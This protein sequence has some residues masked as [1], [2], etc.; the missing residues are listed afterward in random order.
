[1]AYTFYC[2]GHPNLLAEH[3]TTL[4]FT[5]EPELS[6]KGDCIIGVKAK[7]DVAEIQKL[8]TAEKLNL[9]ITVGR[10]KEEIIFT[11]NP[12]FFSSTEIVVR[13]GEFVSER[14][15]GTRADKASAHIN[16]KMVE[17]MKNPEQVIE[18]VISL[19]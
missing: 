8:L 12:D 11:P 7:F 17:L 14:T 10:Y 15:L 9:T 2:Y 1:M 4:E 6:L 5:S 19:V 13:L 3:K 18:V 16:R